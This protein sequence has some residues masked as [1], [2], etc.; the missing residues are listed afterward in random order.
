MTLCP[1]RRECGPFAFGVNRGGAVTRE[2]GLQRDEL[3]QVRVSALER[4]ELH[5]AARIA[6]TSVSTFVR[7][8]A[9]DAARR[10]L[11][12]ELQPTTIG[13]PDET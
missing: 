7:T 3:L 9:Q 10:P 4:R 13:G 6:G 2:Y 12:L 1:E 8:A 5:L 11:R